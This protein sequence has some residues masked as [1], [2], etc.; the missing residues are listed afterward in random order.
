MAT[1]VSFAGAATEFL[2]HTSRSLACNH[3][4]QKKQNC[5]DSSVRMLHFRVQE[6]PQA[7]HFIVD[8][9]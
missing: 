7:V 8:S 5:K 6:N 3:E 2:G 1:F 4:T 9:L